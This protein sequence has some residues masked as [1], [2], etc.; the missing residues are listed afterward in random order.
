MSVL[1][2]DMRSRDLVG[3]KMQ[4]AMSLMRDKI[5]SDKSVKSLVFNSVDLLIFRSNVAF[6]NIKDPVERCHD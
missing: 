2:D 5:I 6:L 1:V 4:H 3:S